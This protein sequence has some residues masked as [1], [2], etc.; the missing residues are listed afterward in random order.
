LLGQEWSGRA[1]VAGKVGNENAQT[2]LGEG[3][4]KVIH[5][6]V[7]GGDAVEEH[8]GAKFGGGRKVFAFDGENLHAAGGG[9]DDV[10]F[11]GVTA[12]GKVEEAATHDK[13]KNACESFIP[14][15]SGVQRERSPELAQVW[16]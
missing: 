6:D 14:L 11:F 3:A 13:T 15:A 4:S 9:V 12:P 16:A 8:D 5:D 2:L 7:V 10:A 1:S